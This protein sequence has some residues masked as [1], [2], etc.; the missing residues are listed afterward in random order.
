MSTVLGF[1][2]LS[3]SRR[4]MASELWQ[5]FAHLAAV[6]ES[7][8]DA[9]ISKTL[10]GRILSW[11][12]AAR[13]LFGYSAE[14][15]VGQS[16][17]LIIPAD[18]L[19][20][21]RHILETLRGGGHIEQL[22]TKRLTKDGRLVDVSVTISPVRDANGTIIGGAKIARDITA[23]QQEQ[24]RLR[25]SEQALRRA[26]EALRT[27]TEELAR[28]SH[29]A[30]GREL[31][32][33]ELKRE[34]NEALAELGKDARYSLDT[35]GEPAP[36]SVPLVAQRNCPV[37]LQAILRTHELDDQPRSEEHTSELQ[38]HV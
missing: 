36:P 37:P 5:V 17:E 24:E 6:V 12:P 9:I 33:I 29:A 30:V 21:E 18:R 7:S 20:E 19:D 22:E 14:E 34:I 1:K 32:I 31:R 28:F 11:N 13:R 16:I 15:A 3:A 25:D 38:S 4:D 26:N 10:D 8:D 35:G 2:L 27:H 23:R